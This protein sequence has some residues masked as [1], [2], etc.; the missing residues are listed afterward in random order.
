M[1]GSVGVT[2]CMNG[3][4][5]SI[6]ASSK[7]KSVLFS[8][9]AVYDFERLPWCRQNFHY[10]EAYPTFSLNQ[11]RGRGASLFRTGDAAG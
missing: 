11:R 6:D 3:R 4:T 7:L 1:W 10:G 9:E 5:V 8:S 2:V